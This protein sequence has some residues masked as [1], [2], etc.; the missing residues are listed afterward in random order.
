[1]SCSLSASLRAT[2][3]MQVS[4]LISG[5]AGQASCIPQSIYA[6]RIAEFFLAVFGT[7][8]GCRLTLPLRVSGEAVAAL[9]LH[10]KSGPVLPTRCLALPLFCASFGFCNRCALIIQ[11]LTATATWSLASPALLA[12]STRVITRSAATPQSRALL[13]AAAAVE[14]RANQCQ[15]HQSHRRSAKQRVPR[16]GR[17]HGRGLRHLGTYLSAPGSRQG[18]EVANASRWTST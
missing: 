8:N 11:T 16:T 14:S 18:R 6:C 12:A 17:V 3:A 13:G 2:L 4:Q 10:G 1:M 7:S 9:E 15:R 5:S